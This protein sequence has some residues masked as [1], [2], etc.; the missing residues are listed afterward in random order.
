M[1]LGWAVTTDHFS[2]RAPN[3]TQHECCELGAHFTLHG[4]VFAILCPGPACT[5][6]S[7]S[8]TRVNALAEALRCVRDTRS[9]VLRAYGESIQLQP[10]TLQRSANS[11]A[12]ACSRGLARGRLQC[13]SATAKQ[14]CSSSSFVARQQ[15]CERRQWPILR[16]RRG[17]VSGEG[18]AQGGLQRTLVRGSGVTAAAAQ[19]PSGDFRPD[20]R[21]F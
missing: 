19:S 2:S 7:V 3:A 21:V 10:I 11:Q 1:R 18:K 12:V 4:V 8:K 16:R 9:L 14:Y 20:C 6:H 13:H 5:A 17:Q 15:N